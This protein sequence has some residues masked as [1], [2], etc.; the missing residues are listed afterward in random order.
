MRYVFRSISC[1]PGWPGHARFGL[2]SRAKASDKFAIMLAGTDFTRTQHVA[3]QMV[4]MP[5]RSRVLMRPQLIGDCSKG[6]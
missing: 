6:L 2:E 1:R 5:A 4:E 3:D